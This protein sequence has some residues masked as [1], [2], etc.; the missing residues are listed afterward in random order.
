M[1]RFF[2][3]IL[4][5][6]AVF[7]GCGGN[8]PY[9]ANL[10]KELPNKNGAY[11]WYVIIPGG[12][13]GG[14][15]SAAEYFV[16]ENCFRENMLFIFTRIESVKTL[17]LKLGKDILESPNVIID[18]DNRFELPSTN[19]NHIYPVFLTLKNNHIEEIHYLSPGDEKFSIAHFQDKIKTEPMLKID[20]ESY[21]NN[22]TESTCSLS[23]LTDSIRYVPLITPAELPVGVL[24]SLKLSDRYIYY[25][26]SKLNI[27]QFDAAGRFLRLIGQKGPGPDEYLG[28]TY[29]DVDEH[30]NVYLFDLRRRILFIYSEAGVLTAKHEMPENINIV[31]RAGNQQ[32]MGCSSVLNQ[33]GEQALVRINLSGESSDT[34]FVVA[35]NEP[36]DTKIDLLR[37]PGLEYS[38]RLYFSQPYNDTTYTVTPAGNIYRYCVLYQGKYRLPKRIA[39]NLELYNQNLNSPYIYEPRVNRSYPLC[40]IEFTFEKNRVRLMYD[41]RTKEFFDVSKSEAKYREGM[42]N[43]IDGGCSFWPYFMNGNLLVSVIMPDGLEKDYPNKATQERYR[44]FIE[45]DNPVLQIVELK[46]KNRGVQK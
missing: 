20:L 12:G 38:D 36:T 3:L 21:M 28:I 42:K 19:P 37:V 10:M 44:S 32:L 29:F 33:N 9:Y 46:G 8:D 17:K 6:I 23:M 11:K 15:I 35:D 43:D 45:F 31:S 14:C 24:Y 41:M 30:D 39:S 2:L 26:D 7:S 34:V 22:G 4:S 16:K 1:K 25:L 40:F 27:F 13:C 5:S 18:A